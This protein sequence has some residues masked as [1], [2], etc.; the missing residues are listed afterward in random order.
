MD[1]PALPGQTGYL[2]LNSEGAVLASGGDLDN[3]EKTAQTLQ[4]LIGLANDR[5]DSEAFEQGF[6]RL[7][8][9]YDDHAY[10]VCLSNR[11]VYIIKRQI[12]VGE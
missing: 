1:R 8:I 10:M 3:D 12:E 4:E 2:I 9:T 5:L 11:K 6:R 7:T